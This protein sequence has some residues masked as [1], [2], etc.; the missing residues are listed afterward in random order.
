MTKKL[1]LSDFVLLREKSMRFY[2]ISFKKTTLPCLILRVAG[3]G[4]GGRG[5]RGRGWSNKQGVSIEWGHGV[6]IK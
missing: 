6:Q 3:G 1:T 5:G 4:G 2:D